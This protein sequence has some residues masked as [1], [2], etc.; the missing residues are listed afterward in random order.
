MLQKIVGAIPQNLKNNVLYANVKAVYTK[1]LMSRVSSLYDEYKNLKQGFEDYHKGERIFIMGTGPSLNKTPLHLLKNECVMGVNTLY[2]ANVPCKYYVVSDS[3]LFAKY[4]RCIYHQPCHIFLTSSAGFEYL[5]RIRKY[6][7]NRSGWYVIPYRSD[8][9]VESVIVA[10]IDLAL[11]MGFSEIYLVGC[12]FDYSGA[13]EH[14]DGSKVTTKTMAYITGDFT[15]IFDTLKWLD[16]I[17][18]H[19]HQRIYNATVGGKLEVFR[20]KTLEEI[21]H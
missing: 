17:A 18:N 9:E 4:W 12:D 2:R 14:F 8:I 13:E 16:H 19:Q 21:L 15:S 3:V 1:L 11:F 5:A 10:C 7:K 20:R 6:Y